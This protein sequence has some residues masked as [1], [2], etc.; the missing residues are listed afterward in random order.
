MRPKQMRQR[1][2]A[3][4]AL[5]KRALVELT[6]TTDVM[7]ERLAVTANTVGR[8]LRGASGMSRMHSSALLARLKQRESSKLIQRVAEAAHGVPLVGVGFSADMR[9]K[10]VIRIGQRTLRLAIEP[11]QGV[12][13]FSVRCREG[14]SAWTLNVRP[15]DN[16]T[17]TTELADTQTGATGQTGS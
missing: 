6:W 17:W 2:E 3:T 7:A 4:A 16:G 12:G 1:R 13:E 11:G 14:N 15:G 10:G 5:V 9:G 8:W